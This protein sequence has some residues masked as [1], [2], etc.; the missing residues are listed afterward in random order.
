[1]V[2]PSTSNLGLQASGLTRRNSCNKLA[3]KA[4]AQSTQIHTHHVLHD[5]QPKAEE[6]DLSAP[7][8]M[9]LQAVRMPFIS[10]FFRIQLFSG[11]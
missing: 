2:N 4:R 9:M 7:V 8:P 3:G 10:A 1:M 11:F 6:G 5:V